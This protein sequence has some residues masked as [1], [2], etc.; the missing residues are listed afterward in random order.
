MIAGFDYSFKIQGRDE[1][2]NNIADRLLD[3]VGTDYSIEYTFIGQSKVKFNAKVSDDYSPGIYLVELSLP[4]KLL[5][6][7]YKLL[8]LFGGDQ[9]SSPEIVVEAGTTHFAAKQAV[10]NV[11]V[12]VDS[13]WNLPEIYESDSEVIKEIRA[14]FDP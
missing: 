12:G 10:V 4:K 14:E 13:S 11:V 3:A 2:H 7:K 1:Y 8:M 5:A 9:I 6:G